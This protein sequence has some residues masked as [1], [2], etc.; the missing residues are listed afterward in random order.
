MK[1][2]KDLNT[3]SF[4]ISGWHVVLVIAKLPG[5]WNFQKYIL[6]VMIW[7]WFYISFPIDI[8][9]LKLKIAVHLA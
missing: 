3:P 5:D 2:S 6:L 9:F 8:A 1:L 7:N 4:N